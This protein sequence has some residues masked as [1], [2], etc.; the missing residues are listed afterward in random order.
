[1][2]PDDARKVDLAISQYV[3]SDLAHGILLTLNRFITRSKQVTPF[4][5][6]S[7]LKFQIK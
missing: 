5:F 1:M 3:Y 7:N 2:Q 6:P 4:H